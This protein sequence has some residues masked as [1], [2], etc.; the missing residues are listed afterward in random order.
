MQVYVILRGAWKP[1]YCPFTEE[2]KTEKKERKEE[3]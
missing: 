1:T 3:R 2:R